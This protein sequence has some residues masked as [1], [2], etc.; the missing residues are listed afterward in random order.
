L[1]APQGDGMSEPFSASVGMSEG[2][3]NV[4]G[5]PEG[6][7]LGV[8]LA[9][10]G[11]FA[12]YFWIVYWAGNFVA[13]HAAQRFQVALPLDLMIPFLPWA[14]VVYLTVTPLL[15]LA[16][17]I[18][19]TP[20][21][22]LPLFVALCAEVTIAGVVFCV[23]PVELSFPA[24]EVTGSAEFFLRL[25]RTIALEHNCVPS[26]HVALTLT[27]AWA[28]A[29]V[30]GRSWRIFVWSW[31]AAIVV[32]TLLAHQHH[33]ADLAAGAA[34]SILAVRYVPP[35]VETWLRARSGPRS[36]AARGAPQTRVGS[37]S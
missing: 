22:L 25:V 30:G 8:N 18:F 29:S 11:A 16:P 7:A 31:A 1:R 34:L 26:L 27:A 32:S 15:W 14:S 33:L 37:L 35:R 6:R 23:F 4:L 21:R 13:A 28:Y 3:G 2:D 12:A 24:Q 5:L 17:F 20:E 36:G 9:L 19:R 10:S